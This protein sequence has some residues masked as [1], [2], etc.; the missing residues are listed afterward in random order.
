MTKKHDQSEE[1]A[2]PVDPLAHTRIST[3][4]Q[5]NVKTRHFG[6]RLLDGPTSRVAN[7]TLGDYRIIRKIGEGGM[8]VVYEA[9]QQNP[10]RLVALKVIRGGLHADD[11]HVKMFEREIEA[12]ARLKHPGIASIYESGKTE[13]GTVFFAME[14]VNGLP[15]DHYVERRRSVSGDLSPDVK[16]QLQLFSQIGDVI[17]HAHQRGVIHR[18]LKPQNILVTDDA[19]PNSVSGERVGVKI[20]DFGLA[21]INDPD[22]RGNTGMSQIGQIKGTLLYMSPEQVRGRPDEIDVRSDVYSLGVMLFEMLTGQ[23]PYEIEQVSLPEAIRII[24][25]EPPKLMN[26]ALSQST[27]RS[28]RID[29]DVQ[30]IVLKA[31]EKEPD[32]RYQSVAAMLD[33]V[34]RYLRNEPI[35]A[36]PPSP[37]YQF[38]KLVERHKVAFSGLGIIFALISGFGAVMAAQ[39]VRIAN[40]R[41]RAEQARIDADKQRTEAEAARNEAVSARNDEARQREIA[42]TNLDRAETEQKRAEAAL[43]KAEEQKRLAQQAQLAEAEQRRVA[44]QNLDIAESEKRRAEEQTRIASEQKTLADKRKAEAENKAEEYRRLAYAAEINLADQAWKQANLA[45]LNTILTTNIPAPGETDLRG[46]EWFYLWKLNHQDLVDFRQSEEIYSATFS[47]GGHNLIVSR[48]GPGGRLG[49]QQKVSVVDMVTAQEVKSFAGLSIAESITQPSQSGSSSGF[50][51]DGK[52]IVWKNDRGMRFGTL[53]LATG[54]FQ[55][56]ALSMPSPPVIHAISPDCKL[57]AMRSSAAGGNFEVWNLESGQR[58]LTESS[59]AGIVT[60]LA[61]SRDGR[62]LAVGSAPEGFRILD[63]TTLKQIGFVSS[64]NPISIAF[65]PDGK[66][67]AGVGYDGVRL[68]ETASLKEIA[69][70]PLDNVSPFSGRFFLQFSPIGDSLAIAVGNTLRLLDSKTLRTFSVVKAHG[71]S[72]T[73]VTFTPSGDRLATVSLDGTLKIWRIV[74]RPAPIFNPRIST[75]VLMRN[76]WTYVGG[77]GETLSNEKGDAAISPDGRHIFVGTGIIQPGTSD[78]LGDRGRGILVVNSETSEEISSFG[79]GERSS[80]GSPKI[81]P[82]GKVLAS[83]RTPDNKLELWDLTARRK[84]TSIEADCRS[85]VFSPDGRF[86]AIAGLENRR[87]MIRIWSMND[88][89]FVNR[90]GRPLVNY[91]PAISMAFSPD[92]STLAVYGSGPGVQFIDLDSREESFKPIALERTRGASIYA[93]MLAFSPTENLLAVIHEWNVR[94]FQYPS[95]NEI[96]VLRGSTANLSSVTFSNDGKRVAAGGQDGNVRI[97]DTHTKKVLASIRVDESPGRMSVQFTPDGRTLVTSS[98]VGVQIWRGSTDEEVARNRG[99]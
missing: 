43:K 85:F 96:A 11:Y 60:S 77:D 52:V 78:Q 20:L 32:R 24:C 3:P 12:L 62:R 1:S 26:K 23:I 28:G 33:D 34:E 72:V 37:V 9:E 46:F 40:E 68:W 56:L 30:T 73:M 55:P 84:I 71:R 44:E 70:A 65:S 66:L 5:E 63:I 4:E 35:L 10:H 29:V 8:G 75:S 7:A 90:N 92:S 95:M 80:L 74:P 93:E 76:K 13:D 27:G 51:P 87:A 86:I 15:L 21:R 98:P 94:I 67:V 61:F 88:N 18:D 31:L 19:G 14:L 54:E 79:G 47:P 42:E 39:S 22:F 49:P 82:D 57:I 99:K 38:R 89:D 6:T 81:S 53:D 2:N 17:S 25:E 64:R 83:I 97:W 50:R 91:W 41:D 69:Y 59:S 58:V 16:A 36:R 45:D 48:L